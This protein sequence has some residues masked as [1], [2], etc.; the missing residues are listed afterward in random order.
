MTWHTYFKRTPKY[1]REVQREPLS[2][3]AQKPEANKSRNWPLCDAIIKHGT[4]LCSSRSPERDKNLV[5]ATRVAS[6]HSTTEE[7]EVRYLTVSNQDKKCVFDLLT[8]F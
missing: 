5:N 6:P 7:V 4:T 3:C 1:D 2:F 8:S